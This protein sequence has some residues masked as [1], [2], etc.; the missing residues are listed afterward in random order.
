MALGPAAK[1]PPHIWLEP[2]LSI[3]LTFT[4]S[5]ALSGTLLL[6]ACD[7]GQ[8]EPA[9]EQGA[10]EEGKGSFAGEVDRSRAGEL[11]PAIALNG[12]DGSQLNSAALQGTPI[13]IN[14]WATWCAPCIKEMPMLDDVAGEYGDSLRVIMISQDMQGAKVVTPFFEEQQFAHLQPWL[15]P[16]S[17]AMDALSTNVLPTT[18]MYDETGQEVWRVVGDYDWSSAEARGLIDEAMGE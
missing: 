3:R 13:L 8:D 14:L 1:R 5:L 2:V 7:R 12:T 16:S 6:A 4:L 18:V 10:L 17:E 11:L 9:Q 15:D